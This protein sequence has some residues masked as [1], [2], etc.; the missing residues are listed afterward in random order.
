VLIS[1]VPSFE[2]NELLLGQLDVTVAQ[3]NRPYIVMRANDREQA[4][5]LRKHGANVVLV[6]EAIA[7][8]HIIDLI[9]EY[10]IFNDNENKNEST[11]TNKKSRNS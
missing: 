9:E 3:Q 10:G 8:D 1:T 7:G 6:P 5:V 4:Q 11:K 2:D